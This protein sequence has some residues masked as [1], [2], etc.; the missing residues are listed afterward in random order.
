VRKLRIGALTLGV[1]LAMAGLRAVDLRSS[2]TDAIR[3]A[4]SR[5]ANLSVILGGYL[6]EA[7]AA[8]DASLRQLA[9]HS[10][11]VGGPSAPERSWGPSLASAKAGLTSISAIT[12]VSS[13]GMI[14]HSTRPEIVGQSR[15]DEYIIRSSIGAAGDDLVVGTPFRTVRPPTQLIIPIGRRL[16]RE[17]GTSDGAV[18]ASFIPAVPR[19]FFG[20]IDVGERGTVW[21]FHPDGVVLFREPSASDPLGE[22]AKKNPLFIAAS[23]SRGS[24]VLQAPITADGPVMLS[25]FHPLSPPPLIVA[26]SLDRDEVLADWQHEAIMSAAGVVALALTLVATLLVLY[27]QM[28]AKAYAE[29]ALAEAQQLESARL[30]EGNERLMSALERERVARREAEEASALKDQFLMTVSHELRTP[31]TAIYGWARMLVGGTMSDR[32]KDAAIRTIERNASVQTRLIDDLLDVAGVMGGKLR[33]DVQPVNIAAIVQSSVET[34]APAADA[35]AIRIETSIDPSAGRLSAD[36]ERLQ[37]IIWN[38]LAN[39]VKFTPNGGRV[40]VT[41]SRERGEIRIS[42][43]D[44]GIGISPEFLPHVF[45][46]FRQEDAG[47]KRHYGGLGLGLAIVK[48][49]VELHGGSVSAQSEGA[50]QG[51]TFVVCLPAPAAS[52]APQGSQPAM[53]DDTASESTRLD[54]VRVLVV[55]DDVEARTLFAAILG[56]AGAVVTCASSAAEAIRILRAA[57]HDVIVSDIEMPDVDGYGLVHQALAIA[58]ERGERLAAIAVT[59]YSRPEDEARS[60]AAGFHRHVQKPVEPVTLIAA[61]HATSGMSRRTTASDAAAKRHP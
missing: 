18:V 59:A 33:L 27:R 25:A 23:R 31:L 29:A 22:S 34:L 50:G 58:A 6:G 57:S 38:L 28:D 10:R 15:R 17:D 37:Q 7:F 3:A 19:R 30:R 36:P 12:V 24:G 11:R 53:L 1:L 40:R 21:V 13:D 49:L 48:T 4:E 32:Q 16:L 44:T 45:E 20:S 56:G 26:V 52:A 43:S 8:G 47:T 14:R 60:L 46:R 2:R 51:A 42:V 39:A 41:A 9:L 55:D 35:K 54:D 61:V 5:A